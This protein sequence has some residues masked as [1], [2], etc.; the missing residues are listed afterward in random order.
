[1]S[2]SEKEM[3]IRSPFGGIVAGDKPELAIDEGVPET[4]VVPNLQFVPDS[5]VVFQEGE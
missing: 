1:M 2:K 5:N 3:G 4:S